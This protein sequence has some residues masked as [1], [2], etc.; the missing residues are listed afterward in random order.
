[1]D[2]HHKLRRPRGSSIHACNICGKEGHQAANCPNGTVNWQDRFKV[3]W[4]GV[5]WGLDKTGPKYQAPK[6]PWEEP[7]YSA[8]QQRAK[9]YALAR[10]NALESGALDVDKEA[11]QVWHR[12]P[13]QDSLS[14]RSR[15]ASPALACMSLTRDVTDVGENETCNGGGAEET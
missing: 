5:V 6:R 9:A 15:L 14:I 3:G 7:D 8:L 10:K 1:M 4:G 2:L 13:Q 12:P 11:M